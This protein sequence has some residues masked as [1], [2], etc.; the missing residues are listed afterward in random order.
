M[1]AG[2]GDDLCKKRTH[3]K[4]KLRTI[5]VVYLQKADIDTLKLSFSWDYLITKSTSKDSKKEKFC[6]YVY[7]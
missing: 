2:V 6:T 3:M 5:S 7:I 4:E 1:A